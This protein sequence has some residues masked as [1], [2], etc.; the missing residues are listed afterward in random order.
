MMLQYEIYK[1]RTFA[2]V[3][4]NFILTAGIDTRELT[5]KI[6][7]HGTMLGKVVVEGDCA[8][9]VPFEDP[10]LQ[11]LVDVVSCKVWAVP[12]MYIMRT[13]PSRRTTSFYLN[14]HSPVPQGLHLAVTI[15]IN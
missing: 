11:N 13:A 14:I 12:I 9:D 3:V 7:E 5:K 4:A 2:F 8:E 6:R 1:N 10:N 15:I